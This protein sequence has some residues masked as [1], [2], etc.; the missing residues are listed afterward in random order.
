[1]TKVVIYS[2]SNL[3]SFYEQTLQYLHEKYHS[4][5]TM[6]DYGPL[7]E[8]EAARISYYDGLGKDP[9][10]QA[11][12]NQRSSHNKHYSSQDYYDSSMDMPV[13]KTVF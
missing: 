10:R 11:A 8:D 9:I 5:P 6:L 4:Q 7:T 3:D 1:M 12:K 2:N 13:G